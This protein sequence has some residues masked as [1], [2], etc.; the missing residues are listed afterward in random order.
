MKRVIIYVEGKSDVASL[1]CLFSD[2]LLQKEISG[3]TIRILEAP[4]GN[5]KKNLLTKVPFI[6]AQTL[7]ND[8]NAHVVIIPD[9]YPINIG[10]RHGTADELRQG[11]LAGF[12]EACTRISSKNIETLQIRFHIFC[13]K[14]DLEVLLLAC[15]NSIKNYL[16]TSRFRTRW[17]NPVEDQN[18]SH[19]PKRVVERLFQENSRRYDGVLDA[20]LILANSDYRALA[21]ACPQ[22]FKPFVDFLE[23]L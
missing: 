14:Y 3:V 20:P 2:L 9:L 12:R 17:S 18:H 7:Y 15:E 22:C 19:P 13:F 8:K 4:L 6:A 21:E 10:F 5:R 16:G 1:E 11:I 23:N